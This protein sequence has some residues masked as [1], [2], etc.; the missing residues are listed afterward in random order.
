MCD[1]N[2][3]S[4]KHCIEK[5]HLFIGKFVL[6][7]SEKKGLGGAMKFIFRCN[8]C[9]KEEISY[10]SS[11]LARDSRR[12]LVSLAL[13]LAF[14]VGGH[15]YGG[16]CRTLGGSLGLGIVSD[17]PFLEIIDLAFPHIKEMLDD[18]T[19]R[20]MKD[21]PPEVIGSWA[22]A[23]TT[24]DG[25]WHIRGHFSQNCTFIIKNYLTGGILYYGHLSMRGADNICDE[26]LW[27]GTSKA[28]EGHLAQVLWAKAKAEDL[29][30]E[31]NW[32][33]GDFSSAKG[34]RYSFPNQLQS[35]VMLCGGHVGRAHGKKL[36]ELQTKSSLSSQYI[37]LHKKDFPEVESVKCCCAGKKHTFISTRNK[38][39]C[40][41]IS[42][43]FIQSAKRNHY[44]A[45]VHAGTDPDKYRHTMLTLGKY[46]SRDIHEWE[47]GSCSFHPL[48]K[49]VCKQCDVDGHGDGM[50]KVTCSGEPYH[51]A[52]VLKCELHRLAY[53]IECAHIAE[54]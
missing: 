12:H 46:H 13:S 45:L 1:H 19:K 30:V 27:Q 10:K 5:R 14:F 38:P 7:A 50:G 23:V 44:C 53:E 54:A 8:G 31:V 51:S 36:Q 28:A 15:G 34:F 32:Q 41:C 40:G 25:C 26:E 47:G 11:Q 17:K 2:S 22:R 43:G 49:C 42:P 52:H 29:V 37:A 33:D 4:V 48:V 18:D 9:W 16:Y 20:Q 39:A 21:I 35:K 3:S 6:A 24:C